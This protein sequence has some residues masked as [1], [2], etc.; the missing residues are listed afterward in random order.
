MQIAKQKSEHA[1]ESNKTSSLEMDLEALITDVQNHS[2][3]FQWWSV[4]VG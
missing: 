1:K 3:R 2:G 4:G